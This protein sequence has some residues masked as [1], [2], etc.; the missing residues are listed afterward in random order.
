MRFTDTSLFLSRVSITVVRTG[1]TTGDTGPTIIFFNGENK[2]PQF[3][4]KLLNNHRLAPGSIIVMTSNTYITEE[5]WVLVS[6]AVVNGY[7]LMP[8][9]RDNTQW[10]MLKLLDGFGSH[11][12]VFEENKLQSKYLVLSA[13]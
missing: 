8:F 3:T 6:K 1:S 13:K 5:V 4:N 2:R 12:Q 9:V 7:R 10:M 11:E